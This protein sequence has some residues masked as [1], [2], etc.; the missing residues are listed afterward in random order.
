MQ[1]DRGATRHTT[2]CEWFRSWAAAEKE[3]LTSDIQDN[4]LLTC[5]LAKPKPSDRISLLHGSGT[6][7]SSSVRA[8]H[9][10]LSELLRIVLS[11]NSIGVCLCHIDSVRAALAIDQGMIRAWSCQEAEV[12]KL[13][14]TGRVWCHTLP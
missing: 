6:S 4:A 9:S 11:C 12:A 7:V 13:I 1:N 3:R 5:S 8:G 2:A 10:L 14:E